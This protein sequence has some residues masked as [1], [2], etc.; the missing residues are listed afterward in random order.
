MNLCL[1]GYER[2]MKTVLIVSIICCVS[3][4]LGLFILP[5]KVEL[6]RFVDINARPEKVWDAISNVQGWDSWDPFQK[7]AD[8]DSRPW[9]DGELSIVSRDAD[10]QEIRYLVSFQDAQGDLS[11]GLKPANEG[12][13][14]R[15][16]HSYVG[17][18]WPWDRVS[19]WFARSE[20]AL[21][22]DKGLAQ[23]K[24]NLETPHP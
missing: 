1:L 17:G 18:Y 11:L 22:F 9:I 5:Q 12:V 3:L 2:S 23:L 4:F 7:K 24:Q 21:T 15:W 14:V 16:H 10:K 8:G 13:T 19:N 20:L 6:I